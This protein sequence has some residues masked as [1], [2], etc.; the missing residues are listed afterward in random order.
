MTQVAPI[1]APGLGVS[2]QGQVVLTNALNQANRLAASTDGAVTV[3]AAPHSGGVV[4]IG[5]A[6]SLSR[7]GDHER[8]RRRHGQR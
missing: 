7:H 6:G 4:E 2:A 5:Q 8:R 1:S 3:T